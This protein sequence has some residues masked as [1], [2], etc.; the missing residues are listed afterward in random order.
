MLHRYTCLLVGAS[1][2]VL[3]FQ[4]STAWA[5]AG[6][7]LAIAMSHK[8]N[9]T[10]GVNGVYTIVVSNTGGTA[11]SGQIQV[12]DESLQEPTFT[13]VSA[14]GG[15][16]SCSIHFPTFGRTYIVRCTSSSVIAPG[17]STFP[18]A[19][20]ALPYVSG[21]VTNTASLDSGSGGG[22]TGPAASDPT[23]IVAAV[24]TLP[25]LAMIVLTGLLALA[26]VTALRRRTA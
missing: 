22:T 21:T 25:Q 24:P 19:L 20:T 12:D 2:A 1:V 15:G 17:G 13:T 4:P 26:G 11:S 14:S 5:Q 7:N 23:I 3:L 9:F 18:I 8:G 10:V 16:W 6:P